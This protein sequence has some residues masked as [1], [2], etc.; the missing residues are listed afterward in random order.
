MS[1]VF[2]FLCTTNQVKVL[3][4]DEIFDL[5][6]NLARKNKIRFDKLTRTRKKI[7]L[8]INLKM[9][10]TKLLNLRKMETSAQE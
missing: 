3:T 5:Y 10:K 7:L 6:K 4:F 2:T 8:K 9:V 1:L